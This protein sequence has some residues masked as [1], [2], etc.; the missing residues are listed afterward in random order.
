MAETTTVAVDATPEPLTV[1]A[2][3]I[4]V[5]R[6]IGIVGKNGRNEKLN[7]RFQAYDDIVA[8]ASAPMARYGLRMLPEVTQQQHF[9]RGNV[10]V[11]ILTVRYRIRGP[12]GDEL[13][14]PLVVVGE[15]ADVSDKATNKAMTAAKKYAFKQAF[16]ISDGADDGDFEHPLPARNPLDWYI[17]QINER[18]VWRNQHALKAV[19]DRAARERC[20]GLYMPDRPD[21]TLRMVIEAQGRKLEA[22]QQER[23]RRQ[24]EESEAVHAQMLAEYPYRSEP[25]DE[26]DQALPVPQPA[27]ARPAV[28]RQMEPE[29]SAHQP[30]ATPTRSTP[31][32]QPAPTAQPTPSDLEEIGRQFK[33]ALADPVNGWQALHDMRSRWGD[34]LAQAQI[35]TDLWGTVDA[36]SAITVALASWANLMQQHEPPTVTPTPAPQAVPAGTAEPGEKWPPLRLAPRTADMSAVER[37]RANTVAELELQAQMLG[38]PTLEFVA[39]LLPEGGTSIEDIKGGSRLQDHVKQHR[40]EVLAAFISKGMS[41]AAAEYSKFGDRVPARDINKFLQGVLKVS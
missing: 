10:N 4:A 25:T 8:A 15:G 23:E 2:A 9:Q 6:E 35:V 40:P 20:D 5:M 22:E 38:V 1:D 21:A 31:P 34:L 29:S 24:A 26:W 7:Y 19:L 14:T 36:N 13:D 33:A 3:M 12:L 39:D 18:D 37:A 41:E 17:S 11:A 30:P 28:A 32:V 16:E 27:A